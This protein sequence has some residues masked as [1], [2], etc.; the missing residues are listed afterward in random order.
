MKPSLLELSGTSSRTQLPFFKKKLVPKHWSHLLSKIFRKKFY[1][2]NV[3]VPQSMKHVSNR[4]VIELFKTVFSR[5]F[6]IFF[7]SKKFFSGSKVIVQTLEQTI[8]TLDIWRISLKNTNPSTDSIQNPKIGLK[9][10]G[11]PLSRGKLG[12]PIVLL[13]ISGSWLSSVTYLKT[14]PKTSTGPLW[15]I[16]HNGSWWWRWTVRD[17]YDRTLHTCM[18][19]LRL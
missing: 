16:K 18:F 5:A 11:E 4:F 17:V 2:Q 14:S 12:A 8:S 13:K 10:S 15:R 9:T 7:Q 6:R 3:S 19:D 1:Y